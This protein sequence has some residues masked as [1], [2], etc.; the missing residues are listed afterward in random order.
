MP[1][2]GEEPAYTILFLRSGAP[3]VYPLVICAPETAVHDNF[4]GLIE[5]YYREL[6]PKALYPRNEVLGLHDDSLYIVLEERKCDCAGRGMCSR[7]RLLG[8]GPRFWHVE[9]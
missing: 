4:P 1:E 2:E 6:C 8:Y 5:A 9:R 7:A 3:Y